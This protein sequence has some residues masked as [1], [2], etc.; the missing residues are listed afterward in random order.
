[1]ESSAD[2]QINWLQS[3]LIHKEARLKTAVRSYHIYVTGP[4][5]SWRSDINW[6][7][8]CIC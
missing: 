4:Q 7:E 6:K 2:I 3:E 5:A 1:M 8:H